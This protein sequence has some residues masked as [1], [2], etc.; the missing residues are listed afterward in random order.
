VLGRVRPVVD[1]DVEVINPWCDTHHHKRK[2]NSYF[3]CNVTDRNEGKKPS[4]VREFA[5]KKR[6]YRVDT[7]DQKE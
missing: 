1:H 3:L 7:H 5:L 2:S 4:T 6:S